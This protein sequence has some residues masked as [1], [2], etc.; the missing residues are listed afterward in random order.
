MY[1][2]TFIAYKLRLLW[3]TNPDFCAKGTVF[4]GGWV[5]LP[6]VQFGPLKPCRAPGGGAATLENVALHFD[7]EVLP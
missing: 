6:F 1:E 7:T 3:H 4:I 2:P 5:G